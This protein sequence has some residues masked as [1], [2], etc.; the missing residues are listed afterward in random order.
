MNNANRIRHLAS[1]GLLA[2]LL[3]G[4]I[5]LPPSVKKSVDETRT[6]VADLHRLHA[7]NARTFARMVEQ[8]ELHSRHLATLLQQ[9]ER[10]RIEAQ[11]EASKAKTLG[12]FDRRV[13]DILGVQFQTRVHREIH[14]KFDPLEQSTMSALSDAR[15]EKAVFMHDPGL[16]PKVTAKERDLLNVRYHRSNTITAYFLALESALRS[17]RVRFETDIEEKYNAKLKALLDTN[18]SDPAV[19]RVLEDFQ[20]RIDQ[21]LAELDEA[22]YSINHALSDVSAFLDTEAASKRFVRHA[23]KGAGSALVDNFKAGNLDATLADLFGKKAAAVAKELQE[24]EGDLKAKAETA[25][26]EAADKIPIPAL[27]SINP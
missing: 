26:R 10:E 20:R 22:Y 19:D 2:P 25:V 11:I 24:V 16:G 5:S 4:C 7:Q 27:S 23:L 17:A 13:S 12:E 3:A 8:R 14:A 1:L 15:A 6:A 18:G 21:N 9:A